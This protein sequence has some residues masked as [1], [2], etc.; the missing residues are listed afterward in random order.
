MISNL[1]HEDI[2]HEAD[3]QLG[4][5]TVSDGISLNDSVKLTLDCSKLMSKHLRA[6]RSVAQL[7]L[8]ATPQ[9]TAHQA[10]LSIGFSRQEYSSGLPFPSPVDVPNP[11]DQIDI[12]CISCMGR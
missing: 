11:R 6:T 8:F 12:S 1:L 4:Q 9:N 10:P 5:L 7:C 2:P 3:P